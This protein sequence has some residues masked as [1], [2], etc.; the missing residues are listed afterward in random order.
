MLARILVKVCGMSYTS[1]RSDHIPTQ[2]ASH[3]FATHIVIFASEFRAHTLKGV[4]TMIV[5]GI[6][7]MGLAL[8][9]ESLPDSAGSSRPARHSHSRTQPLFIGCNKFALITGCMP[10]RPI[11]AISHAYTVYSRYHHDL[12]RCNMGRWTLSPP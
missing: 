11:L 2:S 9:V 6:D 1:V 12:F 3:V 8:G 4:I 10:S 5:F 7:N